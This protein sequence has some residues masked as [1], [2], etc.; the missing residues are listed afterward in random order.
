MA[1]E[2][3]GTIDVDVPTE[4]VFKYVRQFWR[5]AMGLQKEYPSMKRHRFT[6]QIVDEYKRYIFHE[7]YFFVNV[8]TEFNFEKIKSS[9]THIIIRIRLPWSFIRKKLA[10]ANIIIWKAQ[11]RN[12]EKTYLLFQEYQSKNNNPI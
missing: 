1:K 4:I 9:K 3:N 6:E 7:K 2:F 10:D 12:L 5:N 11:I 8:E